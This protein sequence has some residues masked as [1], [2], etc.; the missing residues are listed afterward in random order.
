MTKSR[1]RN[2]DIHLLAW[3]FNSF[4]I[5]SC[6]TWDKSAATNE[7]NNFIGLWIAAYFLK[8]KPVMLSECVATHFWQCKS[9]WF[10]LPTFRVRLNTDTIP[11]HVMDFGTCPQG[12]VTLIKVMFSYPAHSC[13]QKCFQMQ[14]VDLHPNNDAYPK[15]Y[16][17]TNRVHWTGFFQTFSTTFIPNNLPSD[18][19]FTML[20]TV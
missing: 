11:V 16:A 19:T 12:L 17:G 6:C 3:L 4:Y 15:Y 2:I 14:H 13:F 9:L 18:L 7:Y 1:D 8:K 5:I 10:N 20:C